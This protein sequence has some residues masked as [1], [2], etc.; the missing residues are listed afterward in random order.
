ML[1]DVARIRRQVH[2]R[3]RWQTAMRG[4]GAILEGIGLLYAVPGMLLL[5]IL[6]VGIALP[7]MV[8]LA[9]LVVL[10]LPFYLMWRV[11][12]SSDERWE[13]GKRVS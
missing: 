5:G 8:I 3:R 13:L 11:L 9:A 6:L 4:L 1:A 7:A 12:A 2:R 10:Q